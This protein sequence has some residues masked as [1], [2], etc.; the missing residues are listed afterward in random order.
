MGKH[1]YWLGHPL[2]YWLEL[3]RQVKHLGHTPQYESL[4]LENVRLRGNL[5]FISARLKDIQIG[6]H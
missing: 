4:I 6:V 3:E 5:D 1:D 2:A